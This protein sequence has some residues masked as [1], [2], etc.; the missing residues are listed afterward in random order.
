MLRVKFE[1]VRSSVVNLIARFCSVASDF[2]RQPTNSYEE[3]ALVAGRV[4]ALWL[5]AAIRPSMPSFLRM[6]AN[7]D[8][9]REARLRDAQMELAQANRVTATGQPAASIAHEV[10]QPIA[11]ALTN[12]NAA[13]RWLDAE[14]PD[15]EEVGQALGRIITDGGRASDIIGRIRALVR[16]A[17]PRNHQLEVNETM[18]EVIA[19]TRSELRRNGASLQ[20]HLAD[21][22]PLISGDRIQLQQVMLNLI[23]NAVEAMSGSSA[24]VRELLI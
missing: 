10:S 17:P 1:A 18:L 14:P 16:K 13:V 23:L 4:S 22:L 3:L 19:L 8:R 6:A 24:T 12:A 20:T 7:S 11:A 2:F 15:L 9:R 5:S 21:G